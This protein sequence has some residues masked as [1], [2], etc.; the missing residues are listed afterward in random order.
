MES[1]FTGPYTIK[2]KFQNAYVVVDENGRNPFKSTINIDRLKKFPQKEHRQPIG[3]ST[4]EYF[5]T[6]GEWPY[7]LS[8]PVQPVTNKPNP[9]EAVPSNEIEED[10]ILM[11]LEGERKK[12]L[13][14]G[15]A[16]R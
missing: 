12:M 11:E 6:Y 13:L 15:F 7:D 16:L 5:D 9:P 4:W 8:N 10:E 1:K 3:L 14:L 2:E